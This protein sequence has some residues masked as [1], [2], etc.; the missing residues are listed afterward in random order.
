M[1]SAKDSLS[2]RQQQTG[3]NLDQ[4][5][6]ASHSDS[7]S[8]PLGYLFQAPSTQL[9]NSPLN[10]FQLFYA[11]LQIIKCPNFTVPP[12]DPTC[13][14]PVI[15]YVRGKFCT[16]LFFSKSLIKIRKIGIFHNFSKI[17]SYIFLKF[18]AMAERMQNGQDYLVLLIITDGGISGIIFFKVQILL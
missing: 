13:Y 15:D 1:Y 3:S 9:L 7:C 18:L 5:R 16:I 2:H 14:A 4:R 8:R 11:Y 10:E 12:A 17:L 6:T